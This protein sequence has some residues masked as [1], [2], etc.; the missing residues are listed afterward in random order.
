MTRA[1]M[2]VAN[3]VAEFTSTAI[4]LPRDINIRDEQQPGSL[5]NRYRSG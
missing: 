3:Q 5:L 2:V 1:G 4:V